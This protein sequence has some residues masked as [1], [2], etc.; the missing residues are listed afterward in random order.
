MSVGLDGCGWCV[1]SLGLDGCGWCVMSVGLD[2]CG[3]CVMSWGLDGVRC[4]WLWLGA[5]TQCLSASHLTRREPL[6]AFASVADQPV[7]S[8]ISLDRGKSR[9]VD[10]PQGSL[11][12][13]VEH[14]HTSVLRL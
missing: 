12:T 14:R 3:W 13:E 5:F 1:M 4:P 9:T 8:V 11:K 10:Q 6:M 7:G 2:G